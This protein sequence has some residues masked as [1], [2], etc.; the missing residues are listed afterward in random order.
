MKRKKKKKEEN[1]ASAVEAQST[2]VFFLFRLRR[3][4]G[5]IARKLVASMYNFF[6]TF[7]LFRLEVEIRQRL[8]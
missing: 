2:H 4:N 7:L 1:S 3:R 8:Q 5:R 6:V